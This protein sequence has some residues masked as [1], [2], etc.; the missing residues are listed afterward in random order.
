MDAHH[1]VRN[2][3]TTPSTRAYT[4]T[5]AGA[6]PTPNSAGT[7]T[8]DR[9]SAAATTSVLR[10]A[11]SRRGPLRPAA[12][13]VIVCQFD[14]L[15]DEGI[16]CAQRLAQAGV[17]TEL[18]L[19]PGTLHGS[20]KGNRSPVTG[21]MTGALRRGLRVETIAPGGPIILVALMISRITGGKVQ[22]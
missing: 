1:H 3:L 14:P 13:C 8:W 4:D 19:Y 9:A 10:G 11:R 7:G 16:G 21:R 22:D 6:C 12:A 2:R 15:R 18:H 5:P 20:D 17:L